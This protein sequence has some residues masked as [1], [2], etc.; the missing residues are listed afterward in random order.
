MQFNQF[1]RL[2]LKNEF[3]AKINLIACNS[4]ILDVFMIILNVSSVVLF[5]YEGLKMIYE[6]M[7][8]EKAANFDGF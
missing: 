7:Q 3:L 4:K 6:M 8:S 5:V 1:F 2:Y